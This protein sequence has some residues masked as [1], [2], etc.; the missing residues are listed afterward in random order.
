[1][2]LLGIDCSSENISISLMLESK[3]FL[4][5][6]RKIKFGASKLIAVLDKLIRNY[7]LDLKKINALVVGS[8]PGS[9]TGL[10]VSFSL[11]KGLSLALNIPIIS[12]DSFFSIVYPFRNKYRKIVVISDARKSLI[13]LGSFIIKKDRIKKERL[14]LVSLEEIRKESDS[15]F[16][17]YQA[18][19]KEKALKIY[20]YLNFYPKMVYPKAKYLLILAKE[21][22]NRGNFV[23][24]EKLEPL[25]LHPKTC[26]ITK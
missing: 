26:Q 23:P 8:G 12:I 4:E 17:T 5:I 22:Y 11:I 19:I 1:M 21:H 15:F 18:P 13:Y 14:D 7:K 20:P 16:L 2:N 10:R 25:Y 9:F 24:I 6:N 3:I